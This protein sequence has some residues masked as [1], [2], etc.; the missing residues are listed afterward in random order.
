MV[1]AEEHDIPAR[2]A[3]GH[4]HGDGVC[5]AAALADLEHLGARHHRA[6]FLREQDLELVVGG[7][8]NAAVD[9]R[10]GRVVDGVVAV[11]EDDRPAAH[12]QIDKLVAVHIPEVAILCALVIDRRLPE[13][14]EMGTAAEKLNAEGEEFFRPRVQVEGSLV[15]RV[16][17]GPLSRPGSG[18]SRSALSRRIRRFWS[19]VISAPSLRA[20]WA[21][22]E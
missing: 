20:R 4:A 10:L 5:F 2:V 16:V 12:T 21:E 8:D 11:A 22:A 7:A 6:E 19:S 3:A 18:S 9:L 15:L 1:P 17:H 14:R 13:C